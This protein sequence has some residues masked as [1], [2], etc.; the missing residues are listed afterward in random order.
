[1][2]AAGPS[3]ADGFGS[4]SRSASGFGL[5]SASGVGLRSASPAVLARL[6]PGAWGVVPLPHLPPAVPP[7]EWAEVPPEWRR[8]ARRLAYLLV[9]DWPALGMTAPS[10]G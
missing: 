4:G 7:R 8:P 5:R 2:V 1:V 10:P 6:L 3:S 9:A